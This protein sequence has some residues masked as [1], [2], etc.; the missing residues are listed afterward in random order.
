[1][2]KFY[3]S[4]LKLL[5]LVSN[6]LA[7]NIAFKLFCTPINK[8]LRDREIEVLKTA[9]SENIKFEDTFIKKYTWGKGSKTALLVH[10]WESNAG[11]LGAFVKLLTENDYKVIG[12]DCPAHGQSGGKQT[13]L[14]RNSDAALLICNQ[15]G[16]IDIA[17]TH[18]FGSVVLM[19][20]ILHNKNISLDK[21]VMIT[22][23]NELQKAFD[24]FYSLLK[25]S[26]K[27]KEKMEQKIEK[28][29]NIKIKEMTASVLCK[30]LHLKH[31]IIVHDKQD[32]IIPFHNAEIVAKNLKNCQLIPIENAGHYKIL[33]DKRVIDLVDKEITV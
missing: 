22:T 28:R 16:H 2:L 29:Y 13:T 1:M 14:F 30:Q 7:S 11:S 24:D 17:I 25:I 27:V 9:F 33:W 19:N 18:S 15:I 21:L 8:K 10:G 32:K 3:Q 5:S 4:Y 31:A 6:K 20:A 12:F 26:Q 23:P